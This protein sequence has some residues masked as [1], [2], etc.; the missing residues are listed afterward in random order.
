M[1]D[2]RMFIQPSKEAHKGVRLYLQFFLDF[3]PAFPPK[4]HI[5][6]RLRVSG[7][8]LAKVGTVRQNRT[9]IRVTFRLTNVS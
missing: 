9:P 1:R 3:V 8:N 7:A 4:M 5:C 2:T 6:L